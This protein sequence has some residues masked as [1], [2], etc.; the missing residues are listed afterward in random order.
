MVSS[1]DSGSFSPG[2][3]I[4]GKKEGRRR[5]SAKLA[6]VTVRGPPKNIPQDHT[7]ILR[8]SIKE[9]MFKGCFVYQSCI[10]TVLLNSEK[11]VNTS[12]G[13]AQLWKGTGDHVR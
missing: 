10:L 9:H 1:S 8:F 5:P 4:L 12:T 13:G 3:K 2:P 7:S 6:S 11:N